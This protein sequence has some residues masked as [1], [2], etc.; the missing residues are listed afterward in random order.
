MMFSRRTN[1]IVLQGNIIIDLNA[2]FNNIKPTLRFSVYFSF[3]AKHSPFYIET[4]DLS[5]PM[6]RCRFKHKFSLGQHSPFL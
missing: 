1:K 6:N 5:L 2:L 3:K 4:K